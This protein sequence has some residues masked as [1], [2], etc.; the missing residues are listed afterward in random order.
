[1]RIGD[2]NYL[3]T[4]SWF[5]RE[6]VLNGESVRVCDVVDVG[7]VVQVVAVADLVGGFVF[8]DAGV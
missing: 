2:V 5:S 7:E 8:G 6:K 1:L 4:S 3:T